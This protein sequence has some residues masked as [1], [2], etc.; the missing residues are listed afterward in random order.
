MDKLLRQLKREFKTNPKKFAVL[1]LLGVVMIWFWGDLLIPKGDKKSVPPPPVAAATPG[2]G[3]STAPAT[4]V[5]ASAAAPT[6]RWQDLDRRLSNDVRMKS[7]EPKTADVAARN[8]FNEPVPQVDPEAEIQ[9]A[10]KKMI[11]DENSAKEA[12]TAPPYFDQRPFKLSSTIVGGRSRGA[13][14]NGHAFR[15]GAVIGMEAD[16]PITVVAIGPRRATIEWNGRRRELKI[17]RPGEAPEEPAATSETVGGSLP[18]A[19]SLLS[20]TL[21]PAAH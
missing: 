6:W 8:P 9:A 4:T 13:V 16:K 17:L 12:A 18:P 11:A 3:P 14:I 5:A 19:N 7:V 1:G 10:L 20:P 2:A 21:E 15:E